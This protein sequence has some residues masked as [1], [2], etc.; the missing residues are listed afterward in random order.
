MAMIL[1]IRIPAPIVGAPLQG[2][3]ST[4]P[5]NTKNN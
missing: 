1:Y 4:N 5:K 2:T 3:D